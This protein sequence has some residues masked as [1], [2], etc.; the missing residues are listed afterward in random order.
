MLK[1]L[2]SKSID[3]K[4]LPLLIVYL[5]HVLAH[6]ICA[7]RTIAMEKDDFIVDSVEQLI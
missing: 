1:V 5:V 6:A 4:K 2:V 7:L 3:D